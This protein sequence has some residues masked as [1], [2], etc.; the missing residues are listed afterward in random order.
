MDTVRIVR[1]EMAKKEREVPRHLA[2]LVCSVSLFDSLTKGMGQLVA[3]ATCKER[4]SGR[5]DAQ[6][7]SLCNFV[8]SFLQEVSF[9]RR[10]A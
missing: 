10:Q 3:L 6:A 1:M 8:D 4:S 5:D 2:H 9:F 7:L